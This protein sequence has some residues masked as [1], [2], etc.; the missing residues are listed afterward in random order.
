MSEKE[1]QPAVIGGAAII[2]GSAIGAGMFSLPVV[3][4]GMWFGWS[5]VVM[6]VSW[7]LLYHSSLLIVEINQHYPRGA[8]FDTFVKDTLGNGWS[9][10]NG[11]VLAFILYILCYAYISGGG[12]IVSHTLNV[13]IGVTL[14][15]IIAG[16]VFAI[17][18]STIV[19]VSTSLV[20]RMNAI[21]VGGMVIT[22]ILSA[23][24]L[25]T[26]MQL[27]QLMATEMS[28]APFIFAA[29]PYYLASF[30]FHTA[31]PSLTKFYGPENS[32][33]VR[34]CI[35]YG[36]LTSLAVYTLWILSTMG[37]ISRDQFQPIIESGGNIGAMVGALS[38]VAD[39][40]SLAAFLNAFANLAVVSSFL[41]ASIG[42][43][44]YIADKF[45]FDDSGMGR[46]KTALICFVPPTIGGVFFP[47]GFIYAIGL[48]GLCGI[49]VAT[50]IPALSVRKA[51][52][53]F[54]SDRFR[55]WGGDKLVFVI[56]GYG[57]ILVA[58]YFLSAAKLLPVFG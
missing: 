27:P 37:T 39:S 7:F 51:R 22:F 32:N 30:A 20:G 43:F 6:L 34:D 55:V 42:L 48:V 3:S 36:S 33:R 49:V 18:L 17:G 54:P 56:L 4:A 38:S 19:W 28:Y 53:K 25:T 16:L 26:R 31:V 21:F 40:E 2:A 47:N 46:F 12:S 50:L 13:S 52:E 57:L 11:L 41:G 8:S 58:C 35:F 14:P 9:N 5:V 44:D 45:K 23:G 24:D 29:M 15:P 10:F 1:K